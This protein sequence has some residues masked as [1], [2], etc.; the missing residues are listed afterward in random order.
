MTLSYLS[1][2]PGFY[3]SYSRTASTTYLCTGE[4]PCLC[5]PLSADH[6][7]S[8]PLRHHT[9]GTILLHTWLRMAQRTSVKPFL[10]HNVIPDRCIDNGWPVVGN[11][12]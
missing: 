9:P 12:R 3:E 5:A 6:T 1:A 10:Q 7:V 11:I 2:C 8:P 4:S